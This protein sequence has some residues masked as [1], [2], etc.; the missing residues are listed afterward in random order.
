MIGCQRRWPQ[1]KR[2]Q[3]SFFCRFEE[4]E[5][6][7][8]WAWGRRGCRPVAILLSSNSHPVVM[9]YCVTRL[10]IEVTFWKIK[11]ACC[12]W[13]VDIKPLRLHMQW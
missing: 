13:C 1:R 5:I 4:K 12:Y 11:W 3:A 9:V 2:F 6:G 10:V 7:E 8:L